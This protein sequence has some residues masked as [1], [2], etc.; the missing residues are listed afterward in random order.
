[1]QPRRGQA[2]TYPSVVHVGPKALLTNYFAG[3]D[4]DIGPESFK[5]H[6][7]GPVIGTRSWGGVVG[8]RAD[9]AFIDGGMSTQPEF[10]WWEPARG[11][12]MENSGVYPDIVVDILPGDYAAGRDPQLDTAIKYLNGQ[13][14]D[15]PPARPEAPAYPDKSLRVGDR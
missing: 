14:L 13:L 7:L 12:D 2:D 15:H 11:W 3:S 4:G 5:M 6:K 8:I 10:A 9:K 1:M